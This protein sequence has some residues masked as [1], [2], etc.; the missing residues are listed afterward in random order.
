[1]RLGIITEMLAGALTG[2][3]ASNPANANRLANG[4]LSIYIEPRA[5]FRTIEPSPPRSIASSSWVKSSEKAQPDGEILMPGEIEEN[6]KARRLARRHRAGRQHLEG[7]RRHRPFARRVGRKRLR[8]P[9][10]DVL[11]WHGASATRVMV[12][13]RV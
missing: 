1:M 3:G 2:G 7:H 11:D 9:G 13:V 5:S 8:P 12:A 6:T 10:A 4:M